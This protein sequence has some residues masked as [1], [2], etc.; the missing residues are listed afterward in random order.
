[1][2]TEFLEGFIKRASEVGYSEEQIAYLWKSAM[3]MPE[4]KALFESMPFSVNP[5]DIEQAIALSNITKAASKKENIQKIKAYINS[6][7]V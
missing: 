6:V 4:G 5:L 1:M 7:C 3:D 2:R